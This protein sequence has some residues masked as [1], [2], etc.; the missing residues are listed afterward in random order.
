M[1]LGQEYN[2]GEGIL[3]AKV[4]LFGYLR[5]WLLSNAQG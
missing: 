2:Y 4:F 1:I 3:P 5:C